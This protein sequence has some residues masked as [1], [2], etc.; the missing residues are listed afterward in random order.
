MSLSAQP[1]TIIF[2]GTYDTGKP[3]VRILLA[4]ARH[5]G[6]HVIECHADIWGG[7]E[8]KSQ[9]SRRVQLKRLMRLFLS[10]PQLVWRYLRLPPHEAVLV[11]YLGIIDLFVIRLFARLR[12]V[13]VCW[14]IFISLYDTIV[15]DR[16]LAA[17]PL[18]KWSLYG[19]EWLA[20]RTADL[21]I[22]DTRA[23]A[24]YFESLYGLAQ[25]SVQRVFVGAETDVFRRLENKPRDLD[26]P[27]TVLFYGQFIPL[28]GIETIVEAAKIIE[29][30]G[31]P[32]R[33][34]IIGSG[35]EQHR[36]DALIARL[37]VQS[38]ER[39]AWVAYEALAGYI[40]EADV[41]LGIFGAGGKAARVIP[42]KIFQALAAGA[43]IITADT[44]AVREL[45][46]E[47]P[48]VR[49]VEQGNPAALAAAAVAL[50]EATAAG[51]D[52]ALQNAGLPVIGPREVGEQLAGALHTVGVI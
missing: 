31:T 42:N 6:Y 28:Q 43:Q 4:A 26:K 45:L 51:A 44:P 30:S 15:T 41:C 29:G 5:A 39:I 27:F 48:A 19:L 52:Q 50:Q 13:T 20:A 18:V 10:Y 7:I 8:D 40:S 12:G 11:G 32:I 38:I 16:K 14:D 35:Q 34:I 33:W 3:R 46:S 23:H 1:R 2:W 36:I 22:M 49:L 25:G 9:I 24:A 37:G 17:H 21:L 47:G